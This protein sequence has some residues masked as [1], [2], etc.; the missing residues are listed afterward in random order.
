MEISGA[1]TPNTAGP[2]SRRRAGAGFVDQVLSS[3][4]NAFIVL[5]VARVSSVDTFGVVSIYFAS[6]ATALVVGRGALGTPI[7]LKGASGDRT[8]RA[9]V[10]HAL[11]VATLCG[12]AFGLALC[13]LGGLAGRMSVSAPL[14]LAMPF[15]LA[16]DSL[17][18][19][20]MSLARPWSA[21]VSDGLW[22]IGSA[23]LL[24]TT[25]LDPG[26]LRPSL[27]LWAWTVLAAVA[28]FVLLA[29]L[30]I[31]PLIRGTVVWARGSMRARFHYGLEAGFGAVS[32]LVVLSLAAVIV[33]NAAA[34]AL[35]GAG[36]L[37]GPLSLLMAAIPLVVIPEA[38]RS[39]QTPTQTWAALR[40]IAVPMSIVALF[41]GVV[42]HYL[43][44]HV[45]ALLLGETWPVVQPLLPI[46]AVEYA[47]LAWVSVMYSYLRSQGMSRTL[48]RARSWH[49]GCSILL[50]GAAAWFTNSARG[51]AV[52]LAVTAL[53]IVVGLRPV[54]VSSVKDPPAA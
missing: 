10:R 23:G 2:V 40:R 42:G 29:T 16:Q 32:S 48:L 9:E 54:I 53:V 26:L 4:S 22:C 30:R 20:A 3:A 7:L 12:L 45:G 24:L 27:T 43:P 39:H 31:K 19:A 6:V 5:A 28:T 52:A 50:S 41:V 8:V 21:V 38:I 17:R 1:S 36:T 11:T 15:L 49:V 34:A 35:R 33:G 44:S 18:Y 47:A 14:A 13:L 46:T 25:W 37:L 51:V